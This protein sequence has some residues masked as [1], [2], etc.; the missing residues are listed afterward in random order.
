MELMAA[1]QVPISRFQAASPYEIM[2][3]DDK[4]A[5]IE[6]IKRIHQLAMDKFAGEMNPVS[7]CGMNPMPQCGMNSYS[8]PSMPRI[9]P[10]L[11]SEAQ[12]FNPVQQAILTQSGLNPL[13][14]GLSS[15]LP[16]YGMNTLNPFG[17]SRA[18]Q[19]LFSC[20]PSLGASDIQ[21]LVKLK[22]NVNQPLISF[23]DP[24]FAMKYGHPM[25]N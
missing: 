14:C 6:K 1:D 3:G 7:H 20:N 21:K 5:R 16:T 24:Q 18:V 8:Y 23:S 13:L 11:M 15:R 2:Q 4:M 12:N 25:W 10:C 22:V 19:S 9:K 17:P